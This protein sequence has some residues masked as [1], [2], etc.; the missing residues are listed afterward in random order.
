MKVRSPQ[1]SLR[2][3]AEAAEAATRWRDGA[4]LPFLG[5]RLVLRLA[6]EYA[7]AGCDGDCLHLP[8]PPGASPRQIQDAAEAWL[9]REATRI[10][11]ATLKRLA[12]T[13]GNRALP[14]WTL[15]FAAR[16]DWT[17]V[18]ADA[19]LRFNWRLVEQSPRHIEDAL[20]LAFAALPRNLA[21]A[22]PDLLTALSPPPETALQTYS[23]L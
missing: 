9:R 2:L 20:A 6:T 12:L 19:T 14:R 23:P 17:Q 5:G 15:S 11:A 4:E 10:I 1:L 22:A 18:R 16:G 3:E 21:P 8:L 7:A 13:H